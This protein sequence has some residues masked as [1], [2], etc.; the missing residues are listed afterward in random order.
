MEKGEVTL[1][2]QVCGVLQ[3]LPPG[4]MTQ[5]EQVVFAP[6]AA[7]AHAPKRYVQ[8]LGASHNHTTVTT[9]VCIEQDLPVLPSR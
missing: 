1:T 9:G 4:E 3:Q 6:E 5:T 7:M 2:S 8:A